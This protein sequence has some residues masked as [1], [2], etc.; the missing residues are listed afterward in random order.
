MRGIA[1]RAVLLKLKKI[2]DEKKIRGQYII[3][4]SS[5]PMVRVDGV[6]V[7]VSESILHSSRLAAEYIITQ[8]DQSQDVIGF[9]VSFVLVAL[10]IVLEPILRHDAG[11]GYDIVGALPAVALILD[12][13]LMRLFSFGTIV[14]A[15]VA[16]VDPRIVR[17]DVA[18]VSLL[19]TELHGGQLRSNMLRLGALM[20]LMISTMST[21]I[22]YSRY[23]CVLGIE[24]CA[25]ATER[26]MLPWRLE[27][28][29]G[30]CSKY[31]IRFFIGFMV[32]VHVSSGDE[33]VYMR[34]QRERMWFPETIR[35]FAIHHDR[36]YL[37]YKASPSGV[38]FAY[39]EGL[40]LLPF[41]MSVDKERTIDVYV[42]GIHA[43][44][45]QTAGWERSTSDESFSCASR[46][47]FRRLLLGILLR[48]SVTPVTSVEIFSDE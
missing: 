30:S 36:A 29:S 43:F 47:P 9:L 16:L 3:H 34:P 31:I 26:Y 18:I 19:A 27:V 20:A 25:W 48:T 28:G 6:L 12:M 1:S 46:F 37:R 35:G 7:L 42:V 32:G 39:I 45:I 13:C 11:V 21:S 33:G 4:V 10:H 17:P 14:A 22:T 8:E 41:R 24:F 40:G 44:H 38:L 23:L 2:D 5:S 15:L